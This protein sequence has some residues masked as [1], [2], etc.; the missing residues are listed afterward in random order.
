MEKRGLV[1]VYTGNGKGKTTAACGLALRALGHGWRVKIIHFMK[2]SCKY[3]E[4][5]SLEL[6]PAC[7]VLCFGRDILVNPN[8]PDSADIALAEQGWSMAKH[9]FSENDCDLLILDEL[10]VV[11]ALKLLQEQEVIR[12]L[13]QRPKNMEVVITGRY[14]PQSI[15]DCADLITEMQQIKHPYEAGIEAREGIEF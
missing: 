10:N 14:A 5:R 11:L 6:F 3:G 1:Q 13:S 7:Q 9:I 4:N 12:G 2:D 8:N 15:L